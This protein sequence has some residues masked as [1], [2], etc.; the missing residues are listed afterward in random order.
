MSI[1]TALRCMNHWPMKRCWRSSW[2][3]MF[4]KWALRFTEPLYCTVILWMNRLVRLLSLKGVPNEMR[5]VA[6]TAHYSLEINISSDQKFLN[7]NYRLYCLTLQQALR[8]YF[9][10]QSIRFLGY[11]VPSFIFNYYVLIHP[12]LNVYF[13]FYSW[14][15]TAWTLTLV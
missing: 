13:L 4:L 10:Y 9:M 3:L 14:N 7:T 1:P 15:V 11:P 5:C 12:A 6:S 2:P 8:S